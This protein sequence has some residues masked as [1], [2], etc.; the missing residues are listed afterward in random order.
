VAQAAYDCAWCDTPLSFKRSLTLVIFRAQ[1]PVKLTAWKF[2]D[3]DIQTFTTVS[4]L[5][6]MLYMAPLHAGM[7][8]YATL[9]ERILLLGYMQLMT[10][11]VDFQFK[12][13]FAYTSLIIQNMC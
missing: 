2:F 11:N 5:T 3:V 1:K 10:D 12:N 8:L 9:F 6:H 13:E 4:S 7:R